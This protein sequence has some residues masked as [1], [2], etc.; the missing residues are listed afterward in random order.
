MHLSSADDGQPAAGSASAFAR[1]EQPKL[2]RAVT[3]LCDA[4]ARAGGS[5][6]GAAGVQPRERLVRVAAGRAGA[7]MLARLPRLGRSRLVRGQSREPRR[8]SR[9]PVAGE[10]RQE[11]A[12][13]GGVGPLEQPGVLALGDP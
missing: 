8:V 2:A 6:S 3:P 13:D 12:V 7:E 5:W 1:G 10:V 4:A 11:L 9:A